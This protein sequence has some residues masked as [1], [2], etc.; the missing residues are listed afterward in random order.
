MSSDAKEH[1]YI[2]NTLQNKL[3]LDIKQLKTNDHQQSTHTGTQP[4]PSKYTW[5][6]TSIETVR[7]IRDGEKGEGGTEVGGERNY[8]PIAT[9]SPPE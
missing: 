8:I 7:V 9:L 3:V 5:C 2:R 1:N 4:T 6:L